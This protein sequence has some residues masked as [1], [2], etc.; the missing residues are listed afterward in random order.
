MQVDVK[1]FLIANGAILGLIV[2]SI[3]MRH[4]KLR[5]SGPSRLNM[6]GSGGR[7]LSVAA[8]PGLRP[9]ESS[10]SRRP[11][12]LN[13]LFEHEGAT[14]DAYQVLRIPAGSSL[15]SAEVSYRR[16]IQ[17]DSDVPRDLVEGAYRAILRSSL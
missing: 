3:L 10:G 9:G 15:Q 1:Y 14:W 11:R 12:E 7:K 13:V 16:L 8:E 5:D 2:L 17:A 4:K 6:R